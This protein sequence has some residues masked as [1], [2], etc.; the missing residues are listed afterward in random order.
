MN[1]RNRVRFCLVWVVA[2]TALIVLNVLLSPL[3]HGFLMGESTAIAAAAN[4]SHF[5]QSAIAQLEALDSTNT[6]ITDTQTFTQSRTITDGLSVSGVLTATQGLTVRGGLTVTGALSVAGGLTVTDGLMV[7]GSLRVA[8][9]LLVMPR[10]LGKGVLITKSLIIKNGEKQSITGGLIVVNGLTVA[11]QL[12]V[13]EGLSVTGGLTVTGQLIVLGEITY[14]VCLPLVFNFKVV[15]ENGNFEHGA[16]LW[17]EFSQKNQQLIKPA[18][19]LPIPP[20]LGAWAA[21]LG[22]LDDEV[23]MIS[24]GVSVPAG[25]SCLVYWQWTTSRDAC[26]AD[27]GGVGVNG[28]WEAVDPLCAG[29]AT[30]RWVQREVSLKSYTITPTIVL[31][32]A[33]INDYSVPSTM[34]VDNISFQPDSICANKPLSSTVLSAN[35]P[36]DWLVGRPITETVQGR[37]N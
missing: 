11:G 18:G 27:Y 35:V 16:Q 3:N 22:V 32:F 6:V 5:S 9:Q 8:D 14:R 23:S 28:N 2:T 10:P 29:T 17:E 37:K 21:R 7:T 33:A 34:Y 30:A 19:E 24:Q 12:T 13:T 31:N 1:D 4:R 15:T 36:T 25:Q 26:N 20:Q